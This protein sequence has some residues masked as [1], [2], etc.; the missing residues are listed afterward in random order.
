MSYEQTTNYFDAAMYAYQVLGVTA[1][2]YLARLQQLAQYNSSEELHAI[3]DS[4]CP[5]ESRP[6]PKAPAPDLWTAGSQWGSAVRV[7]RDRGIIWK[8][9]CQCGKNF[10]LSTNDTTP[11]HLR[12]CPTCILADE[13][14]E[15]KKEFVSRL[16]E[17]SKIVLEWHRAHNKLIWN[18]VHK[19]CAR[20]L[21]SNV[22]WAGVQFR[23][24]LN[25]LCWAK[26]VEKAG[27]YRDQGFKP[28][29]WLGR[30]ADNAIKDYFKLQYVGKR[31]VRKE[32][33]LI[34]ED[35]REAVAPPTRQEEVLPAKAVRPE[36]ASPH[37]AANN[38]K[39]SAW[40]KA[41]TEWNR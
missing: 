8:L 29:A 32:V 11:E 4:W 35:S 15:T 3:I 10:E 39:E 6:A 22:D 17:T 33:A 31:D 18:R 36:G 25:A 37:D 14:S 16:D 26:I 38:L 23:K 7:A 40:D 34:A 41:Q 20:R 30:V 21:I 1:P 5:K 2:K 12:K 9:K 19:A 24:E 27:Q 28:S 13:F